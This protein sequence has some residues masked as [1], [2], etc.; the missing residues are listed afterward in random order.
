M[1]NRP[2]Q[3]AIFFLL[4]LIGLG[5]PRMNILLAVKQP[6]HLNYHREALSEIQLLAEKMDWTT[7]TRSHPRGLCVHLNSRFYNFTVI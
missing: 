1:T 3:N 2:A 7:R 6:S 4:V 5:L